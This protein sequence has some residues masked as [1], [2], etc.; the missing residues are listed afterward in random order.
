LRLTNGYRLYPPCSGGGGRYQELT[1]V[2]IMA[3]MMTGFWKLV[4]EDIE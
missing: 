4:E 3:V 2:I 1:M